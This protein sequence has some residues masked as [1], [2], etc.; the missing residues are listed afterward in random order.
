MA[1]LHTE[2]KAVGVISRAPRRDEA[3]TRQLHLLADGD[4]DVF[5]DIWDTSCQT[6][7]W[8]YCLMWMG[9]HYEDAE[10]AMST[11]ALR[12]YKYLPAHAAHVTNHRAW[13]KRLLYNHCMARRRA[14]Q[15]RQRYI[16][17]V[18]EPAPSGTPRR[19]TLKNRQR[20]SS[21]RMH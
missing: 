12:A 8:H 14:D 13:L 5:W 20:R 17:Y 11:A 6:V 21:L 7:F 16:Q 3:V 2:S 19:L 10:D 4:T 15:S 9:G 1:S 18:A